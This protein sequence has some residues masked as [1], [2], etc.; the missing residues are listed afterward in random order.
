MSRNIGKSIKTVILLISVLLPL[1]AAIIPT[2][3]G[4]ISVDGV[5]DETEYSLWFEDNSQTPLFNVSWYKDSTALYLG[6]VIDDM[7]DD[8]D[9]LQFAFQAIGVD[10]L[11]EIKPGS[12]IKYRESGGSWEG[13]WK[14]AKDGLPTG[15]VATAG[16]TDGKRSYELSIDLSILGAKADDFPDNFK[17][18]I[19]VVDGMP[20]GSTN[21][22]PDALSGWWW[23]LE[24]LRDEEPETKPKGTDEIPKFA[25]PELPIGTVM[26]LISS[27]AALTLFA[28]KRPRITKL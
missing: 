27:L 23:V 22:Y 6:I 20:D 16:T 26:A 24:N 25:A 3:L 11:I 4:A 17:A 10:Y 14:N 9:I 8:D 18:W 7:T 5:V 12:S 15:V 1:T 28:V 19:K 13:Y 21:Y 2:A